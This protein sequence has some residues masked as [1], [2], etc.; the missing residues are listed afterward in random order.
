M[1]IDH[2]AIGVANMAPDKAFCDA[3]LPPLGLLPIMPVRVFG[4]LAGMGFGDPADGKPVFWAQLPINGRPAFQGNGAHIAF[5]AK[6]RVAVDALYLA[7]MEQGAVEDGKPGPRHEYHP[8][9]DAAFIRDRD[10]HR[11]E[12]VCHAAED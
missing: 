1:A 10:G 4:A 9:Y 6:S 8:N 3:V 12:A 2:I 5:A 7:A 11:I